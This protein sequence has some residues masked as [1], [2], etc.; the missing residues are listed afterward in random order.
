MKGQSRNQNDGGLQEKAVHYLLGLLSEEE[1]RE[2]R[3]KVEE[4]DPGIRSSLRAA[5][6]AACN[7]A[8]SLAPQYPNKDLKQ[9]L[10]ARIREER[11]PKL[12]AVLASEGK[13]RPTE[14]PGISYKKLYF[15]KPTGLVTMLVKMAPGARYPAHVHSLTEQC[16]VLEG[17]LRHGKHCYGPGDFTWA[18][19]GSIDPEL[20]TVGGN[21]LL[22]IAGAENAVRL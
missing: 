12:G 3:K 22:I 10:L 8:I 15:D 16:L 11:N 14:H 19:A 9:R 6:D 13:W 18:E 5:Q 17:D 2:F 1:E 20:Q 7:L 4:G 21:L